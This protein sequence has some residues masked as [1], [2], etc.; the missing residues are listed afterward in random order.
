MQRRK[1]WIAIAFIAALLFAIPSV[2]QEVVVSARPGVISIYDA[3]N[4]RKIFE[5]HSYELINMTVYGKSGGW[6]QLGNGWVSGADVMA[7]AHSAGTRPA[8]SDTSRGGTV[9]TG[10][11]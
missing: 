9:G 7:R 10:I 11:R 8:P 2:A 3:P 5:F 1:V 4:G 6:I